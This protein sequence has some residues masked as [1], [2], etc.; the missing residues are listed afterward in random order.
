MRVAAVAAREA[1]DATK[2]MVAKR[3][4]AAP[5]PASAAEARS[6][7]AP[8]RSRSSSSGSTGTGRPVQ[9]RGGVLMKKFVNDPK[10][11]VP[12]CSKGIA[13][14]NPDTLRYVPEYNLIMRTDAPRDDKVSIVQGSGSG[15][16]P[17]HVMVV[18]KGMLDAACPGDV[19]AAP[20]MDYVYETAK[21]L[22]SP[23]GRAA[24]GQQLHR[25]PDGVRHGQGDGRGR[26]AYAR[27]PDRRRRRR[28]QGLDVHGRA[29]AGWP[30]TSS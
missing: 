4:R 25:R 15:H 10:N 1:A 29:G 23:E 18:G 16:E 8:P 24:A 20:P 2:E 22:A 17:A 7:P 26:R 13:L 30:A 6:T 5:T 3:G 21:L 11:Y 27:R 14:A 12:R 9:Q 19:F 28:R